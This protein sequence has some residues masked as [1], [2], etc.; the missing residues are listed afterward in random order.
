MAK[1]PNKSP[2]AQVH[3]RKMDSTRLR[4][5]EMPALE[6]M[7]RTPAE[8]N[9]SQQRRLAVTCEYIDKLLSDME[10][11]LHSAGSQSP[12]PRYVADFSP[13]QASVIEDHIRRLRAQLLR[14]LA[15]QH[16]KPKAPDIP[17]TRAVTTQLAF[18]EIAIEEMKPRYMRGY[19]A[20]PEDAAAELNDV[21]YEL[22]S[23]VESTE[24]YVRRRLGESDP[25]DS[26]PADRGAVD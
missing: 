10:N 18:I 15:W 5:R 16:M 12:F 25:A 20:V 19:G 7:T 1:S 4:E 8:L 9:P 3:A 2:G 13:A 17:A 23:L 22:R 14:V 24:R 11:V 6:A 21:V 26:A